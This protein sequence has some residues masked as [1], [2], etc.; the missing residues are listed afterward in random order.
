[1]KLCTIASG[2][3]GNCTYINSHE[4][5]ILVDIGISGKKV[6]QA[7]TEIEV[8]PQDIQ[9]IFIT[10]EHGDH[11]KGVG[12]FSRKYNTPI[13]ATQKTW[14]M[15]DNN[16][17]IGK[18]ESY[19]KKIITPNIPI[20]LGK[21]SI[22]AYPI[23]HDAVEPVG[24]IFTRDNKKIAILTDVGCINSTIIQELSNCNGI[25]LEFNHDKN[26]LE[27]GNYPYPLKKRILGSYGH[28]SNDTAAKTLA[29]IYHKNMQ[30]AVLAHLS[31]DNN[32]PDLA[33]LTAKNTLQ[34]NGII[35][36]KDLDL[37]IANKNS[38]LPLLNIN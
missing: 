2:S 32:I 23:T 17:L 7:L 11:I 1:M 35:I 30:W 10:H 14:T 9:A 4:T 27:V 28:L 19:N 36:G 29:H 16:N 31:S 25:M 5:H 13:Y 12:I 22:K 37:Y 33:Y 18:V 24:Y 20:I 21:L 38:A 8:S 3:S 6:V 26:M 34:E 15:L